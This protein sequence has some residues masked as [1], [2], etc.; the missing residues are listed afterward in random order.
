MAMQKG[1]WTEKNIKK[2]LEFEK[3]KKL[4]EKDDTKPGKKSTK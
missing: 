4:K 2:I 3:Q 1:Q